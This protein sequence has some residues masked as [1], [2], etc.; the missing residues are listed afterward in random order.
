MHRGYFGFR[1]F[2]AVFCRPVA[3]KEGDIIDRSFNPQQQPILVVE[4]DGSRP[5]VV[6]LNPGSLD[7]GFFIVQFRV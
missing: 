1:S 3:A 6:L 4:F 7:A 2:V 5:H